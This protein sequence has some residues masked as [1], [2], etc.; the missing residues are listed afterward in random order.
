MKCKTNKQKIKF[1]KLR[2]KYKEM[3]INVQRVEGGNSVSFLL[4]MLIETLVELKCKLWRKSV[5]KVVKIL[6]R[7]SFSIRNRADTWTKTTYRSKCGWLLS[8]SKR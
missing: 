3:E 5:E 2:H 8:C 7:D 6:G 4:H 1:T